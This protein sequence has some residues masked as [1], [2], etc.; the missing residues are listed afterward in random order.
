MELENPEGVKFLNESS[1][2]KAKGAVAIIYNTKGPH[3]ILTHKAEALLPSRP[4]TLPI[5]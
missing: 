2:P 4:L 3:T 5:R 1:T